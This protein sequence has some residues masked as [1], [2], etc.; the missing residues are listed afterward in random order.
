[1]S[2]VKLATSNS[3]PQ[4]RACSTCRHKPRVAG[5]FARCGATNQYLD[6]ERLSTLSACGQTGEL[7]EPRPPRKGLI[8]TI[9]IWL[10]GETK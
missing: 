3:S 5:A 7:W 9:R 4:K 10:F 6:I 8:P 1:M 2:V